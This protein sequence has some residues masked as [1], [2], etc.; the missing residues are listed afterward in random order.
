M[1]STMVVQREERTREYCAREPLE[2]PPC[3]VPSV[4]SFVDAYGILVSRRV[5]VVGTST[6]GRQFVDSS[7]G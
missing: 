1:P 7:L 4:E 2:G 3:V 5:L 6:L